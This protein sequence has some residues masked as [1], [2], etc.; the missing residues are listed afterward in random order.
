MEPDSPQPLLTPREIRSRGGKAVVAKY[1]SEYMAQIGR[2][3]GLARAIGYRAQ[4]REMARTA[5]K[6]RLRSMTAEQRSDVARQGGLMRQALAKQDKH[7][8]E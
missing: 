8:V 5:A 4:V 6:A 2:V 1:G 7:H 3:G